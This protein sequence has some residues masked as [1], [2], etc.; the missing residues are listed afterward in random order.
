MIHFTKHAG[1][2]FNILK[3]H[4]LN[5]SKQFIIET[6]NAPDQ[7]DHSRL[8]LLI[9]Q[10]SLDSTHVLRVVYKVEDNIRIIITFYP[11]GIK[12]YGKN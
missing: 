7:I 8:P 1:E 12:Q 2:K 11:G 5:I 9:A 6:V 3:K 10:K 4:S